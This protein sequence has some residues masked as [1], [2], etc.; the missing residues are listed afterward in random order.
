MRAYRID[1]L[2]SV[3]GVVLGSRDDPRP[4][5]REILVRMRATSLNYRDP[6]SRGDARPV[7]WSGLP[8]TSR[9][10]LRLI[11]GNLALW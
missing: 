4:A 10:M 11:F 3:D 6:P 7:Y 8:E 2:G 1:S 5:T 9:R